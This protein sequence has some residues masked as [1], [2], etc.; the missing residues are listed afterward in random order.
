MHYFSLCSPYWHL[1]S[2]ADVPPIVCP[3]LASPGMSAST[4]NTTPTMQAHAQFFIAGEW[5]F[6]DFLCLNTVGRVGSLL[7]N[8]V[9]GWGGAAKCNVSP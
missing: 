1:S 4:S 7:L 9:W 6:L 2:S 8:T 3:Y 5:Y